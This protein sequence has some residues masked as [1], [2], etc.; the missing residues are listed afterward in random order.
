MRR[1]PGKAWRQ[2]RAMTACAV[3]DVDGTLV[4]SN[5]HHVLAWHR[6]FREYGAVQPLW[7]IHRHL[8]M[9][10]DKLAAAVAGEEVERAHGDA[11]RDAW[12]AAFDR[13]I[14]EVSAVPGAR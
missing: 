13:L 10:G 5:Y 6:A 11:I 8:G 4:D 2:R 9:G 1:G 7:Q 12:K 14:G 3:F